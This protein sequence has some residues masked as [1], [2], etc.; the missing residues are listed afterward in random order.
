MSKA[1][2]SALERHAKL[3]AEIRGHDYRYYVED[4]PSISDR[5]YDRLFDELKKLEEAYPELA[6]PDS[7]TQRVGAPPKDGFQRV[8]HAHRMYSLN[9][10]YSEDELDEFLERIRKGRGGQ[11][12]AYVVEP[13]LDGASIEL[14][15]REGTL[16]QAITR[17]DGLVGED[18]TPNIRTIRTLP[19]VIP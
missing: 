16:A 12:P 15:Y 1:P 7:P 10:T 11:D 6:G 17:G 13:K 8:K 3:A 14:I 9:N 2:K 4:A 5:E 19:L 18:V